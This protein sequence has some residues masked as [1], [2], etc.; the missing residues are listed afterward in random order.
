MLKLLK[1]LSTS[2]TS[3]A[4]K[5]AAQVDILVIEEN[6]EF[7]SE[8]DLE[9]DESLLKAQIKLLE[10]YIARLKW[11]VDKLANRTPVT[12]PQTPKESFIPI[13]TKFVKGLNQEIEADLGLSYKL[14]YNHLL[15]KLNN[16][17]LNQWL[18]L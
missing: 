7:E 8:I 5:V 2:E 17:K 13:G 12:T 11:K 18:T 1:K 6:D 9:N 3:K 16:I 4:N 15:N 14:I 10:T